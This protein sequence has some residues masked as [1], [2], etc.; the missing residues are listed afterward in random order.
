[1]SP[2]FYGC[3][4][5]RPPEVVVPKGKE[6]RK[7]SLENA[8]KAL[9]GNVVA[10]KGKGKCCGFPILYPNERNSLEMCGT[11]TLEA[12]DKGADAMVTP[13]PL[14][15]LELDGTQSRAAQHKGKKIDLP[16]LH[17]PQLVGT[18]PRVQ[19]EGDGDAEAPGVDCLRWRRRRRGR[20]GFRDIPRRKIVKKG[21]PCAAP[22]LVS[23][24]WGV[25]HSRPGF[26]S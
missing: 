24:V 22:S 9:G 16:V 13:C 12:K 6:S 11:H 19:P 3:Y 26:R 21:P 20:L 25:L 17:L 23:G 5:R 2:A 10:T 4:L 7:V 8:I 1:M 18:G 14:C 15:H